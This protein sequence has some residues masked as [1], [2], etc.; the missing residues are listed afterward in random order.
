VRVEVA[1]SKLCS[2][3]VFVVLC[4]CVCV[5]GLLSLGRVGYGWRSYWLVAGGMDG[6]GWAIILD[7]R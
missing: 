6:L 3:V 5:C 7:G 2:G 4:V 1:N